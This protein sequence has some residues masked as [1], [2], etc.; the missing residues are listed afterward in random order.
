MKVTDVE[1]WHFLSHPFR[2]SASI[3]AAGSRR[4]ILDLKPTNNY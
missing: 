4:A 2:Q 1:F 3:R